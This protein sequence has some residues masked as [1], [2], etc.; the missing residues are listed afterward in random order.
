M[1]E[2]QSPIKL[3][4]GEEA[5]IGGAAPV[6]KTG[7][8]VEEQR[9]MLQLER[10][11]MQAG[12]TQL[13]GQMQQ[14]YNTAVNQLQLQA[15]NLMA[16]AQQQA[17]INV[18]NI[19]QA[20]NTAPTALESV[21][22]LPTEEKADPAAASAAPVGSGEE[23]LGNAPNPIGR[24]CKLNSAAKRKPQRRKRM[25]SRTHQ[26]LGLSL[27]ASKPWAIRPQ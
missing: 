12:A 11:Q 6:R 1:A 18:P 5:E 17:T 23:M 19:A 9:R 22:D 13:A 26:D 25:I 7:P 20:Q 15:G 14:R 27:G 24:S 21:V 4:E 3:E 8:T 16:Q 10:T 2:R